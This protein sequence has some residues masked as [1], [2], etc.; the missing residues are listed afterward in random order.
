MGVMKT[1][2]NDLVDAIEDFFTAI[3]GTALVIFMLG[4]YYALTASGDAMWYPIYAFIAVLVIKLIK[5]SVD[6]MQRKKA[7]KKD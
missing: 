3:V 5:D 4:Q 2:I 6:R 1:M 7:K